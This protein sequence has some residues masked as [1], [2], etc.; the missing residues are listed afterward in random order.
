MCPRCSPSVHRQTTNLPKLLYIIPIL[1]LGN[2]WKFIIFHSETIPRNSGRVVWPDLDYS[3]SRR[4]VTRFV[5][6]RI[7]LRLWSSLLLPAPCF[8]IPISIPFFTLRHF[9]VMPTW[10]CSSLD[11]LTGCWMQVKIFVLRAQSFVKITCWSDVSYAV[12]FFM[13]YEFACFLAPRKMQLVFKPYSIPNF[14]YGMFPFAD[15]THFSFSDS[16]TQVV[17]P[18]PGLSV[19]QR[20]YSRHSHN[21]W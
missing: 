6:V 21:S 14:R 8:V 16:S 5:S 7:V 2:D 9:T 3:R 1:S 17:T 19:Q 18:S 4:N 12:M 11:T 10:L 15:T 13:L 20:I